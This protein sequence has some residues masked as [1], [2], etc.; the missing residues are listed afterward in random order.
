MKEISEKDRNKLSEMM[1]ISDKEIVN[2]Q[3]FKPI[4]KLGQIDSISLE[5][6]EAQPHKIVIK[7]KETNKDKEL[8][9]IGCKIFGDSFEYLLPLSAKTLRIGLAN[10]LY[11]NNFNLS[12]AKVVIRKDKAEFKGWGENTCYRVQEIKE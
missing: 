4:F 12:G 9:V 1:G 8:E 3:G 5:F 11:N 6:T 2:M 7:D 10:V